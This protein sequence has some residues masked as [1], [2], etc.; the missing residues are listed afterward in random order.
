VVVTVG[1]DEKGR[2][3]LAHGADVA[4]NY[5][6]EDFV[7]KA[8][9]VDVILDHLGA[10]YLPRDIE[11]LAEG[12]RVVLI[13]SMG[14]E[15][16]ATVDATRILSKRLQILGSVMR[17]RPASAKADIVRS[18]LA[19]FGADLEAGRIRPVIHKVMALEQ[20]AEAHRLMKSSEHFGKIV[21][22]VGS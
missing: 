12:G 18:F 5:K 2:Q 14:G 7:E 3:C 17:P 10:T 8:R 6:T 15:R 19:R 11:T 22:V 1:S 20:A 16:M 13:G 4:I 21:L 9:G